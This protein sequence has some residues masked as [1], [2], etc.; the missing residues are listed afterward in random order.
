MRAIEF[1]E[2]FGAVAFG[3]FGNELRRVRREEIEDR[4]R[5]A[6]ANHGALMRSRKKTGAPIGGT[7]RG[8]TAHV[9]KHNE[10]WQIAIHAAE[11][12]GN[13][14]AHVWKSGQNEAGV[15]H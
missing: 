11:T 2:K 9:W 8:E 14:R 7:I 5:F 12:V 6:D 1:G 3:I 4:I 15:L 13:P 10:R